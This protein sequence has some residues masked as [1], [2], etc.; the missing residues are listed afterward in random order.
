MDGVGRWMDNR[1]IERLWWSTKYEDVYLNDYGDGL[2]A[3]RGLTHWFRRYNESRPH[4][5]LDNA[6]PSDWYWSPHDFGGRPAT[7]E[8]LKS[9]CARPVTRNPGGEITTPMDLGPDGF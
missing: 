4:S 7:W 8:A 1:F 5:S 9:G 2:A 6:T 3:G